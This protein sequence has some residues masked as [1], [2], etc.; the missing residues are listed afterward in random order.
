MAA[1]KDICWL[2]LFAQPVGFVFQEGWWQGGRPT[3]EGPWGKGF[4]AEAPADD[5]RDLIKAEAIRPS[6]AWKQM[7]SGKD[8]HLTQPWLLG[9]AHSLALHS[10][11]MVLEE[12]LFFSS[13]YSFHKTED[14]KEKKRFFHSEWLE[15]SENQLSTVIDAYTV[16][17]L[18]KKKSNQPYHGGVQEV[19]LV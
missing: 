18:Q 17:I 7:L 16:L 13:K 15:N 11:D 9:L 3:G 6:W 2:S 4:A 19:S 14:N 1:S 12:D 8:G 5:N 10:C